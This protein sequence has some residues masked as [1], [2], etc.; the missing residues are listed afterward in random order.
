MIPILSFSTQSNLLIYFGGSGFILLGSF[1]FGRL[2]TF[3]FPKNPLIRNGK[4][5]KMNESEFLKVKLGDTILMGED[6]IVKNHACVGGEN[7]IHAPTLFQFAKFDSGEIKFVYGEE[8]K[9]NCV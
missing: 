3:F 1:F 6:E 4:R 9:Q 5:E 2:L 8:V 7:E